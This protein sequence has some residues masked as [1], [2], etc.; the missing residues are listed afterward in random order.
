MSKFMFSTYTHSS[1]TKELL[2]YSDMEV[3]NQYG[4]IYL[5]HYSEV[6]SLE[7][8]IDDSKFKEAIFL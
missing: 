3:F 2:I 4:M 6:Y 5:S 7:N 8:G 1:M